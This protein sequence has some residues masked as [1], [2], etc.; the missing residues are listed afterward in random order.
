MTTAATGMAMA[1]Q[2]I[3]LRMDLRRSAVVV[4]GKTVRPP[5]PRRQSF[6]DLVGWMPV[7]DRREPARGAFIQPEPPTLGWPDFGRITLQN[8]GRCRKPLRTFRAGQPA[9]VQ[10]C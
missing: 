6:R 10:V 9:N 7:T 1:S 8:K 2:S 5:R 4:T 3:H